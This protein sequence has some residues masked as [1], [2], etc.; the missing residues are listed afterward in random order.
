MIRLRTFLIAIVAPLLV[1]APAIAHA[2]LERAEPAVG[3]QGVAPP[4]Q[5]VLEFS[6]RVEPALS[7][8]E[9]T[10]DDGA[11]V[12][13]AKPH[14]DATRH[15]LEAAIEGTLAPGRYH[16]VWRVVSVDGHR[17]EGDFS[18]TVGYSVGR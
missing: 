17:S 11:S 7:E 1:A 14:A 13:L 5:I 8:I 3:A 9:L 15:R 10:R 12:A 18:F 2:M 6:E 16:L 4:S